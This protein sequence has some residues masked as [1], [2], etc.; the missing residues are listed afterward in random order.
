MWHD[1]LNM[2]VFVKGCGALE[3]IQ[4]TDEYKIIRV[5]GPVTSITKQCGEVRAAL[6][7]VLPVF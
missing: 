2:K 4:G 1:E 7:R 6:G 5:T 3:E